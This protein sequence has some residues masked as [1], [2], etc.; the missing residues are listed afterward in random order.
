VN[1]QQTAFAV[2]TQVSWPTGIGSGIGFSIGDTDTEYWYRSKHIFFSAV[3]I[4][5][6][7]QIVELLFEILN[8]TE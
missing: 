3:Q 6:S 1:S 7:N 8:G 4:F 5:K 2:V